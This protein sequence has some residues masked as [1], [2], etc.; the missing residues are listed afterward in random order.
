MHSHHADSVRFREALHF[1]KADL[2]R[3]MD[4]LAPRVPSRYIVAK[5]DH[6]IQPDCERF[7]AKRMGATTTEVA[8]SHAVM[9]SQPQVVIDVIRKPVKGAQGAAATA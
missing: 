4:R 6:T 3:N 8:S 7:L 5:N 9:Q 2:G 1:S